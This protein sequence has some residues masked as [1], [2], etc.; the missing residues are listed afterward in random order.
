MNR[1]V[2]CLLVTCL[3]G[4]AA[5]LADSTFTIENPPVDFD[6]IDMA[7]FDGIGDSGPWSTFNIVL[8]GSTGDEREVAEFDISPFTVPAGE[9]IS[10]ATFDVKI[11]SI[12]CSGLGVPTGDTPD[13]LSVYGFAGNGLDEVSDFEAGDYCDGVDTPAPAVGQVL[14]FDVTS[15]VDDLVAAG[16]S[17]VGLTVRAEEFG[18]MAIAEGGV[19]PRLTIQTVL[20]AEFQLGDLNC[21][22]SVDFFD[23]DA[24]VLAVTDPAAYAAA[25]PDCDIM[26]ADINGDG[27]VNFFDIDGFVALI[28]SG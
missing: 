4:P 28:V 8:L 19:F 15:L 17:Y 18:G 20:G 6:V 1:V 9:Y 3:L 12:L 25:Y 24:F 27:S 10:S 5:V 11:T 21:D 7:P 22:G 23:I 14:S 13:R 26:L 16:E 2:T